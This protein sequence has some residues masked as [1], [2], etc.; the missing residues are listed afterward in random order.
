MPEDPALATDEF[1]FEPHLGRK[2]PK[3]NKHGRKYLALVIVAA[4]RAGARTGI[5]NRRFD[6]SRMGRGA[7]VGRVLR[8]GDRHA[9]LRARRVMVKT[10]LVR[11]AGKGLAGAGAHLRY[12]QR[13]GVTREGE[14]GR[15]YSGGQDVA[16]GRAFLERCGEDRH[17]FRFIVSAEDGDQ[18]SDLKPFVRRLMTQ[19][20]QDLGT[21]LDWVAADHFNSGHPHSHIMLRGRDDLGENLVIAR[22]YISHGLRERAAQLVAL[23]LGPRTDLEIEQRLR[24]EVGQERL[25]SIDR[26]LLR[27]A[28]DG[29]VVPCGVVDQF[30]QALR[31]GR[32]QKLGRLGLA[33]ELG[34]G[35][36][37]LAAVMEDA[38]RRMG[39]RGDIIRT[40]QRELG[41]RQLE[42]PLADRVIHEPGRMGPVVGRVVMRG[43]SDELQ[44]RHFL[45]VDGVD[46]RSHYVPIGRGEA[47]EPLAEGAIVRISPLAAGMRQ[48][49]RTVAEIAAANGGRYDVDTHLRHDPAA[50]QSFAET[51]VRRL[52]RMRRATG[53]AE[54]A[55]DGSW[56]IPADHLERAAAFEARQLRDRPVKVETLSPVP[57]DRLPRAEAATWLDR[58]LVS[59][60]P[61]PVR[62]SGFGRE[63]RSAQAARRQWLLAEGLAESREG[64]MVFRPDLVETLRRRELLRVAGQLS[65]EMG[66]PFVEAKPAERIQGTLRRAVEMTSGR[67]A[68]IERS[69]DFTLVPWRSVLERHLGKSV[70]GML[71]GDG[72][73]W[74]LGRGRGGPS[75][76]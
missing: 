67:H 59:A 76:Q 43:L 66:I 21:K 20:E 49:D 11:L 69:R 73:N 75:I 72:I 70:S 44:D 74:T 71:R 12:I 4:R 55:P 53:G 14:P 45:I 62:D 23:D 41:A 25:T 47:V 3:S 32:L 16:D 7:G 34:G 63:L 56:L 33:E 58:E 40:M 8:G 64:V 1:D 52:E 51:H 50:S 19:M 42:R 9:G 35:R 38:L 26:Q 46:G 54:R 39:E 27:E 17:Q 22:E 36:W 28:N 68:L 24:V 10:R 48:V 31:A 5:R 18:Y 2:R 57:L 37:R 6:G 65:D 60:A 30:R 15:L 13:D 61:E 29:R